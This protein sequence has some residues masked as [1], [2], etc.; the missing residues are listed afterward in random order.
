MESG[1]LQLLRNY[2]EWAVLFSLA[3]SVV[4]AVL[5]V[6]PSVFITA[7][8]ILYFGFWNGLLLSLAGEVLGAAVAFLLYRKGFKRGAQKGLQ[9]YPRLEALVNSEGRRAFGLIFT[10]RLLP[11]VPSG[12]VTLAAAIGPVSTLT[13][14]A[15][16]SLGKL[17]A[18]LIEA[19]SVNGFL[20]LGWQWKVG[21]TAAAVLLFVMLLA[22]KKK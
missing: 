5:G 18:L 8:N 6:L 12:L 19:F 15:A 11:F 22:R 3:L 20:Q 4:V 16:S 21:I 1:L 9:K 14:L 13:F 7:A 10:L 17:P 2:P